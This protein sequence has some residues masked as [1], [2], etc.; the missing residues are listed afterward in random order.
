MPL[1]S[2]KTQIG[3]RN[4]TTTEG[5]VAVP[6][7]AHAAFNVFESGYTSD[8]EQFERNP[9]RSSVGTRASIAGVKT[10]SINY[11]TELAGSGS[12]TV[13]PPF[14]PALESCG[15]AKATAD[16]LS[17]GTVS[18]GPFVVGEALTGSSSFTGTVLAVDGDVLYIDTSSTHPSTDTIEGGTSGAAMAL[19]GRTLATSVGFVYSTTSTYSLTSA[20]S[21]T[22]DLLND[23]VGHRII[24]ARGNVTF[25]AQTGQP[26]QAMFE[27]TGP[28]VATA[29]ASL[30]TGIDYPTTTPE[31]LLNALFTVGGFAAV[32]DNIE[33]STNNDLQVRRSMNAATGVISTQIVNRAIGGSIDPEMTVVSGAGSHD[34]FGKLD[35]N[36]E[37]VMKFTVGSAVGN[38]F[39]VFGLQTQYTGITPGDRNGIATVSVDL[40]LNESTLGDDDL[41]IVCL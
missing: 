26:V 27:F 4:E 39:K 22:I 33:V 13:A 34:W 11:T 14:G 31:P 9:F 24:G 41:Q 20:P 29:N 40:A 6:G 12:A 19:S 5:T 17:G 3:V 23:G 28:K 21:S 35:T 8:I 37:G 16:K 36:V 18:G 7:A 1:L 25:R 38:Q 15:F 32:L 10:G 30:L 2:R